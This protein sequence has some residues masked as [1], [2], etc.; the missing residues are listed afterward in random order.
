MRPNIGPKVILRLLGAG[1]CSV[2]VGS[3]VQAANLF[4][5]DSVAVSGDGSTWS[6]AFKTIP[7]AVDESNSG[8]I[9]LVGQGTYKPIDQSTPIELGDEVSIQGGFA[10]LGALDP[11][12]RDTV[13]FPTIL[14]GDLSGND[15]ANFTNYGD[16][17]EHVVKASS[18]ISAPSG[19]DPEDNANLDGFTIKAGNAQLSHGGGIRI[20]S[21]S[22]LIRGCNITL[23]YS[24]YS[25]GGAVTT[26]TGG[27]AVFRNCTFS[28]NEAQSYGGGVM[29]EQTSAKVINC[30]FVEN[31]AFGG[32]GVQY[33]FDDGTTCDIVSCTFRDNDALRSGGGL[34]VTENE[35]SSATCNVFNSL[36]AGNFAALYGGGIN[37]ELAIALTNCTVAKNHCNWVGGGM[38][39]VSSGGSD[40]TSCI[41][42]GNT[43]S[44]FADTIDGSPTIT[45][46]DVE[47]NGTSGTNIDADPVFEDDVNGDYHLQCGSPCIGFGSNAAVVSDALYDANEDSSSA[48]IDLDLK[49][50]VF[51]M[52]VDMGAYE[53]H[54]DTPD[55]EGDITGAG[56]LPNG[57]VDTDDLLAVINSWGVCAA[58]C[59]ADISLSPCADGIVATDDLLAVINNWGACNAGPTSPPQFISE[60]FNIC[61]ELVG[62][63]WQKCMN[64]CINEV[65]YNNPSECE[66]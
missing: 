65:C 30:T 47:D 51:A 44:F 9:I 43:A 61:E 64:A 6:L 63:D 53:V 3:S 22:P 46:S 23:N 4:V 31:T 57:V 54:P 11:F 12:A 56:G 15:G 41:F 27:I 50:R 36:F 26:G 1:I 42:W 60:C 29:I 7:E 2:T 19:V 18:G 8:D 39:D 37:T 49:Q 28:E 33:H 25:G 34:N 38:R 45:Y 66:E 59:P 24:T 48:A 35:D 10:G 5:D 17:A 52:T 20:E 62:E 16:N 55:C 58:P 13:N 32:G 40:I 21:S 14:S